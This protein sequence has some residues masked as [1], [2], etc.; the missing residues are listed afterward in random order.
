MD[1]MGVKTVVRG[2]FYFVLVGFI[3]LG[4]NQECQLVSSHVLLWHVQ[5]YEHSN[6]GLSIFAAGIFPVGACDVPAALFQAWAIL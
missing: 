3:F 5:E 4:W 6:G 2:F 1:S